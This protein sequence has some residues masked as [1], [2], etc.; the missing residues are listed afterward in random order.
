MIQQD[1]LEE[2]KRQDEV[3]EQCLQRE[4]K[5][6]FKAGAANVPRTAPHTPRSHHYNP[7]DPVKRERSDSRS[8][9]QSPRNTLHPP[10]PLPLPLPPPP[11]PPLSTP[12]SSAG[13]FRRDSFNRSPPDQIRIPTYAANLP[14]VKSTDKFI[15][16]DFV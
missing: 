13:W 6:Q 10:P 7:P 9:S 1:E 12:P 15:D 2:K 8:E 14:S 5:R 3:A 11:P 16:T 4:A